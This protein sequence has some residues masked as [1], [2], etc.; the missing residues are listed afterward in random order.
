VADGKEWYRIPG[1]GND[2]PNKEAA[3][4]AAEEQALYD[5]KPVEVIRCTENVVR[6]Y[7]RQV[8]VVPEDVN[9]LD[10]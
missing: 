7:T 5:N 4:A 1:I 8:T 6:R 3:F 10:A 2:Y 9:A